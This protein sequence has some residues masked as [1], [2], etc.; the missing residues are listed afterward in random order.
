[1][2]AEPGVDLREWPVWRP[3]DPAAT[4]RVRLRSVIASAV[5]LA[6]LVRNV[7]EEWGGS[8]AALVAVASAYAASYLLTLY[9]GPLYGPAGRTLLIGWLY[10]IGAAFALVTGDPSDLTM[11]AYAVAAGIIL[12]PLRWGA[13]LGL[14]TTAAV[15]AG[16][17]A[18]DGAVDWSDTFVLLMMTAGVVAVT[19]LIR[20]VNQLRAAHDRIRAL[21][22]ADER[23]RLA[24]DLH[25]V[26]GHSLTTITVKTGL[27]RRI[28]ESGADPGRALTELGDAER[29]SR[30][31]LTEI[32]A[33]VSG[34]R[35]PSLAAE[36]AG[37]H[38]ALRAADIAGDLPQA[39]DDVAEELREPFAYVLRE[40]VTNVIRHSGATRCVVRMGPRCLEIRDDGRPTDGVEAGSGLTGLT[41]RMA[42]VGGRL[43]AESLPAK[44][45]RLYAEA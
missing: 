3:V 16:T 28:L 17:R 21:A 37:A 27:A 35:R 38:E 45:F 20:T 44:G 5:F 24:R 32:R 26:L 8:A 19:Q 36:L 7:I 6:F 4:R 18:V 1:M 12:L 43:T 39:V 13:A 40:G 22:V 14:L 34:Y 23:S 29:L 31:A 9:F 11:L 41:E 10:V 15:M 2:S 30:Q 25:D 42:A 33:T